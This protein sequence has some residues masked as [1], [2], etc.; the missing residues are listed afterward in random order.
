MK[1]KFLFP[2]SVLFALF[3]VACEPDFN[4]NA[5]YRDVTIVYGILNANDTVHYVKIYKGFQSNGNISQDAANWHNLYYFDTITVSLIEYLNNAE[6]G[7]VIVLDTTTAIPKESGTFANPKQLLYYTRESLNVNANY[8]I[9]IENKVTGRIVTGDTKIVA[10]ITISA[11]NIPINN[12]LNLTGKKG[13]I[14]FSDVANAKG[15]EIFQYF[16]YFEVLKSSGEIV[17]IGVVKRNI[18]NN[19]FLTSNNVQFAEINKEY[20]PNGIYDVI[21]VQLKPDPTVDRYRMKEGS[22]S[23]EVWGASESLMNYLIVNQ[24]SSSIVQERLE[25]TNMVCPTD[26][27][28]KTAYGIISSRTKSV[29]NYNITAASEDSLVKGS[30]TKNLGFKYYRDYNPL[31]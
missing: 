11:P 18:T 1:L 7:R 3:F 31:K 9:N 17:K 8:K 12:G 21:A 24:P 10:P 5:P 2:I 6:T 27:T 16:N 28:Y 29:K 25:Y 30:K 23:F 20:N 14:I 22:V 26:G 15:Y 13:N 4:L 19:S